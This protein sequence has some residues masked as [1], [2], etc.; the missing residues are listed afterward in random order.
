MKT[1]KN[2]FMLPASIV[3]DI[4]V[5]L[6]PTRSKAT[7]LGIT[8]L[9]SRFSW[10]HNSTSLRQAGDSSLRGT[11]QSEDYTNELTEKAS[12][13]IASSQNINSSNIKQSDCFTTFAM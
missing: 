7:E 4:A 12:N 2:I 10:Q 11:K 1:I 9:Y 8:P 13:I 3:R 5:V 6:V